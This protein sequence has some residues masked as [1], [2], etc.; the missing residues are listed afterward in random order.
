M[1][2]NAR[3][4]EGQAGAQSED[5]RQSAPCR[6]AK[7]QPNRIQPTRR[8]D[9]LSYPQLWTGFKKKIASFS[10]SSG[11]IT[12][13]N[14]LNGRSGRDELEPVPFPFEGPVGPS[15]GS[16]ERND[17]PIKGFQPAGGGTADPGQQEEGGAKRPT[18]PILPNKRIITGISWADGCFSS[19][20]I[21]FLS[22]V[23]P[24]WRCA[25]R[26]SQ[27]GIGPHEH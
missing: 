23:T 8:N 14:T 26:P 19:I 6:I 5:G 10:K 25:M 2:R 7:E 21:L 20:I 3:G 9:Y 17:I 1:C 15:V 11:W 4:R 13:P 16:F 27:V 22:G 12:V 18:I 24:E